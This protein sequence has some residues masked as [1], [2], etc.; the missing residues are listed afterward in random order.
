[1]AEI[2]IHKPT[3]VCGRAFA[4]DSSVAAVAPPAPS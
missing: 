1:M 4:A 3:E 2:V